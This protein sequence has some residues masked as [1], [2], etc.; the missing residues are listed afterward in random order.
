M[1]NGHRGR[2]RDLLFK[3]RTILLA[4]SESVS[5]G[6]AV[7]MLLGLC[8]GDPNDELLGAWLAK[9]SVRGR[10]LD[11]RPDRSSDVVGQDHRRLP[12]RHSVA[13][14]RALGGTLAR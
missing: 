12:S 7:R 2:K 11:R 6:G 14:I 5:P 4:A 1:S 9:E 13:E 8:T 10:V 3:I